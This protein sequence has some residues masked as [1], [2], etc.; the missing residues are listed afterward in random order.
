M[1]T[2]ECSAVG[3]FLSNLGPTSPSHT[4]LSDPGWGRFAVANR[5][6]PPL[7]DSRNPPGRWGTDCSPPR[8]GAGAEGF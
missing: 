6:P 3:M 1:F 7:A 5:L 4:C 2:V 8:Q